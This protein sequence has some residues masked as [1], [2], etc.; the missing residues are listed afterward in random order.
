MGTKD[1]C[2]DLIAAS[3]IE[4]E[5]IAGQIISLS[6]KKAGQ[7]AVRNLFEWH[8]FFHRSSPLESPL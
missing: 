8:L 1:N 3:V 4:A 5:M 6:E 2:S 7:R